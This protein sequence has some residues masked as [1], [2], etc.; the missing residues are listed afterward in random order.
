MAQT[1]RML[2]KCNELPKL[3]SHTVTL[4]NDGTYRVRNV[5]IDISKRKKYI[6]V[7]HRVT[8]SFLLTFS[9]QTTYPNPFPFENYDVLP[10]NDTLFTITEKSI[11]GS[12]KKKK[13]N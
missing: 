9:F 4:N 7:Y 3:K 10:M 1:K 6:V 5:F 11:K 13:R 8:A 12:V 2:C